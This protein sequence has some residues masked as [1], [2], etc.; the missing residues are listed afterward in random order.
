MQA[1][2]PFDVFVTRLTTVAVLFATTV[3][4]L[5]AP[6]TVS[7][8]TPPPRVTVSNLVLVETGSVIVVLEVTSLDWVTTMVSCAARIVEVFEAVLR[9]LTMTA[10][11]VTVESTVL[12]TRSVE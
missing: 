2:A 5:G 10:G 6:V 7:V 12:V 9:E 4:V 11:S 3:L 1:A 8:F